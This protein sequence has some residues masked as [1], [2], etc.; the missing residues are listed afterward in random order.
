MLRRVARTRSRIGRH[1][2]GRQVIEVKL[3]RDGP[4][5]GLPEPDLAAGEPRPLEADR[6][7]G[8]PRAVEADKAS[9]ELS[10]VEAD[11]AA[12][13]LRTGE[14]DRAAGEPRPAEADHAAGEP[15]AAEA[16]ETAGEPGPLEADRAGGEPRLAEADRAAQEPRVPEADLATGEPRPAEV[17]PAAVSERCAV[18]AGIGAAGEHRA[19]K[20]IG[21][22]E[23]GA[24]EIEPEPCPWGWRVLAQMTGDDVHGGLAHLLL[25]L[26]PPP[27]RRAGPAARVWLVSPPQVGAQHVNAGLP[28]LWPVVG[29]PGHRMDAGQPH[30]R[31]GIP[32]LSCG[33]GEPVVEQPGSVQVRARPRRGSPPGVRAVRHEEAEPARAA[34]RLP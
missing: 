8:E 17:E 23:Y 13:E 30:A 27:D 18:E 26:E 31:R 10:A 24:A 5:M 19:G 4:V 3:G 16:D 22:V 2:S 21:A 12:G 6:P 9:G 1:N 25:G 33:G 32:K 29:Q 7:A 15:C 34:G 20:V 14:A 11:E 28:V